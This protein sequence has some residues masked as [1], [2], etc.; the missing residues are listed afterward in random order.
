V[1]LPVR[2]EAQPAKSSKKFKSPTTGVEHDIV[3]TG[4]FFKSREAL[5]RSAPDGDNYAPSSKPER[6]VAKLS[7][8]KTE[9][10]I[11]AHID[12]LRKSLP[13][14]A[15][16]QKHDPP[17][18]RD[19]NFDRVDE[20]KRNVRVTAFIYALSHEADNDYHVIIGGDPGDPDRL[21]LNVE[22]SGLPKDGLFKD[23]LFREKLKMA[24][25]QFK[26]H[27]GDALPAK[28]GFH[29]IKPPVRVQVTGSLFYDIS[30][31]PDAPGPKAHKP[32]TSW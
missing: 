5:D 29:E 17:I 12:N 16:M 6:M 13:A 8:V 22:V 19:T 3:S 26:S 28:P 9:P 15:V 1:P 25:D 14:D 20:E 4:E 21:Y 10:E 2:A 32:H 24:R 18:T 23:G 30:H 11:F 31:K 7:F 27:F